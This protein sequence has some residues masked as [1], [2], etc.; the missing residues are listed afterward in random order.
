MC[1]CIQS[2]CRSKR[3]VYILFQSTLNLLPLY[4]RVGSFTAGFLSFGVTLVFTLPSFRA[5]GSLFTTQIMLGTQRSAKRSERLNH[6]M[7]CSNL[8]FTP[9]QWDV[10]KSDQITSDIQSD[11]AHHVDVGAAHHVHHRASDVVPPNQ[12]SGPV[13]AGGRF[14]FGRSQKDEKV[15]KKGGKH[16]GNRQAKFHYL[17]G[18]NMLAMFQWAIFI[19]CWIIFPCFEA[20]VPNLLLSTSSS[21]IEFLATSPYRFFP[22]KNFGLPTSH[23]ICSQEMIFR[24]TCDEVKDVRL[25]RWA[26]FCSFNGHGLNVRWRRSTA[27][28]LLWA[29]GQWEFIVMTLYGYGYSGCG[30][31]DDHHMTLLFWSSSLFLLSFSC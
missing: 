15:R 30:Y 4:C 12:R 6:K 29:A 26:N 27:S 20:H 14:F 1:V 2:T 9:Q 18:R 10:S 19:W 16:L 8:W 13:A 7:W 23:S 25:P 22:P 11:A 21:K 31:H 3:N 5:K 24:T 17:L 28:S